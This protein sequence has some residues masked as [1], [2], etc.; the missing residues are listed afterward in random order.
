[1]KP[2]I[3][4]CGGKTKVLNQIIPHI[5]EGM[6]SCTTYHE[7]FLGSGAVLLN[8]CPKKA[9]LNDI[10][11]DLISCYLEVKNN[12]ELLISKLVEHEKKHY[13]N[14]NYFFQIREKDRLKNYN[15][16]PRL[17]KVARLIYLLST[18]Y[19]GL[20]RYNMSGYFNTSKGDYKNPYIVRE[21]EII[22]VSKYLNESYIVFKSK[23]FKDL[24]YD[25]FGKQ[26]FFYFDPPY[27]LDNSFLFNRNKFG[28]DSQKL[29]KQIVDNLSQNGCNVAIS[30]SNTPFIRS[31]YSSYKIVNIEAN[32]TVNSNIKSRGK[33]KELLI[34][35]Y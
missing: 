35:N 3:K 19:N 26:N 34:K 14:G 7:Y 12:P 30:N 15:S 33:I 21:K 23:N 16:R 29:L 25:F 8:I 22:D 1:M 27:H 20:P 24:R 9:V 17:F 4:W 18:C 5:K 32:R 31:L 2:F 28:E 13:T 6:E 10:N 11:Y